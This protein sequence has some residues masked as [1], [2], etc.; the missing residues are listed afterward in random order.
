MIEQGDVQKIVVVN[1]ETAEVYLKPDKVAEYAGQKDYKGLS[2][3]GAPVRVQ[4]RLAGL[5]PAQPR[6]Y[7]ERARSF[8]FR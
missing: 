7:A 4:Y 1:K 8:P 3:Q 2:A 5:F 6:E